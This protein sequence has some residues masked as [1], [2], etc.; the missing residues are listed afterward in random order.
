MVCGLDGYTVLDDPRAA[1]AVG[2][3]AW[4]YAQS[5]WKLLCRK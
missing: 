5:R 4:I 3:R 1:S 2:W